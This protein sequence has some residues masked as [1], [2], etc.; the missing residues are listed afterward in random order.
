MLR[1]N[2]LQTLALSLAERRGWSISTFCSH[3]CRRWKRAGCWIG[4]WNSCPTMRQLTRRA[5]AQG[6]TRPELA[7]LLAYSKLTLY[8]E[9][10]K[11]AG[12]DDA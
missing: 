3:L 12:P 10:L 11:S 9:L 8:E 5:A 1:D 7:V 4:Q 2:Y 6:L